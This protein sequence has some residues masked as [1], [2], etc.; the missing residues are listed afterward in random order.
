[1]AAFETFLPETF[2]MATY[3]ATAITPGDSYRT[4]VTARE[5]TWTSDAAIPG[6]AEGPSPFDLLVGALAACKTMTVRAHA[7]KRGWPMESVTCTVRR[8]DRDADGTEVF[9]VELSLT[10]PLDEAQQ[11]EL[12]KASGNCPVA[13][14]MAGPVRFHAVETSKPA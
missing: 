4:T 7:A 6:S 1:M 3:A 12:R 2:F 5:H 10:G 9:E 13:R 11:Q 8:S 14:A